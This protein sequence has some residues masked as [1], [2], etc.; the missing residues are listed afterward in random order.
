[1]RKI[2]LLALIV[3]GST[4]AMLAQCETFTATYGPGNGPCLEAPISTYTS[5]E[6]WATEVYVFND[7]ESGVTY[8]FGILGGAAGAWPAEFTIYAPSG[9]I[10]AFG[11]DAGNNTLTFT[12]TESGT[13]EFGITNTALGCGVELEV[14]NGF[15]TVSYVSGPITTCA[16]PVTTCEAGNLVSDAPV[17]LLT[18]TETT[19]VNATGVIIPNSPTQGGQ[20]VL[21]QPQ[22]GAG[23]G[24][25]GEFI[26]LGVTLPYVFDADLNGILSSNAFPM[27]TGLYNVRPAVYGDDANVFAS[28]C[29]TT[30]RARPVTF[31]SGEP[32]VCEGGTVAAVDQFLCPGDTWNLDAT[33]VTIP[34]GGDY[35]WF[36]LNVD[37]NLTSYGYFFGGTTYSGDLNADL[38]AA[39]LDVIAPG[40]YEVVGQVYDVAA[41]C[42]LTA[43]SFFITVYDAADPACSGC[44]APSSLDVVEIGFGTANARVNA[45]WTNTEGTSSCEV[46]GG[47]ISAASYAAG[48]PEFANIINTQTITQTNGSTVLFNIVLYNN[49][50]VPF[51]VGQRY[52]YEVRCACA[53]DSG[54]SDWANITPEATFLVPAAPAGLDIIQHDFSVTEK[55]INS[56]SFKNGQYSFEKSMDNSIANIVSPRKITAAEIMKKQP[57]TKVTKSLEANNMN[58][59]PNPTENELNISIESPVSANLDLIVF[60]MTGRTVITEQIKTV[61]GM[62]MMSINVQN[63][64]NGMYILSIGGVK[65]SFVKK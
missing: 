2:I 40:T 12:A 47:R 60:D 58:L 18:T 24:L 53:D 25:G 11:N 27:M 51:V 35:A 43:G 64:E 10:N 32:V 33:G 39:S 42:A 65:Q 48:E 46:R 37:T 31:P 50:N 23:G 45:T 41:P 15:A 56:S 36:F 30:F 19:D 54:F 22:A 17:T 63:L 8:Q 13:Y 62:N 16:P 7:I 26:L 3:M 38:A 59:F 14:D 49:P 57:V 20:G 61:K 9:A 4:G 21:F 5:F 44:V 6:V 28:V 29:D 1:M 34:L 52:G 55:A